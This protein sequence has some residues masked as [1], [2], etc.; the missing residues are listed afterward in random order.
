MSSCNEVQYTAMRQVIDVALP[1]RNEAGMIAAT[2]RSIHAQIADE[3]YLFRVTVLLNACTDQTY[4]IAQKTINDL[5]KSPH[6]QI[7]YDLKYT[8][9]PGKN[10]ALNQALSDSD[11]SIFMYVDGD[12]ILSRNCLSAVANRINHD[13]ICVS[14]AVSKKII[15]PDTEHAVS[16]FHRLRST[17]FES[18]QLKGHLR[19]PIGSMLAFRRSLLDSLPIDALAE[20]FYIVLL[21]AF[22][23]G[24]QASLVAPDAS[25][26]TVGAK[27]MADYMNR[28]KRI[29]AVNM[30]VLNSYPHFCDPYSILYRYF[31]PGA[32]EIKT[33]LAPRLKSLDITLP[34]LDEWLKA[35]SNIMAT[36]DSSK[37][38][39]T[40]GTWTPIFT[41]KTLTH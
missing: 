38:L 4:R 3:R 5:E 7:T 8:D 37:Y 32:H 34:Q 18:L 20:D 24:P 35:L 29:W 6:P 15:T 13:G 41:T 31:P 2:L 26:Y 28:E 21:A 23:H 11:T 39:C 1:A 30:D 12:A 14:G 10:N 17:L 19:Q 40:D 27:N 16:R 33:M 36:T 9:V 22:K 25:V